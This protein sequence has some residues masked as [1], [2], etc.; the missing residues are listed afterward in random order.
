MLYPELWQFCSYGFYAQEKK[1]LPWLLFLTFPL[2]SLSFS[3]SLSLCCECQAVSIT[4][5]QDLSF[6]HY[7]K[8]QT[9]SRRAGGG[10]RQ[11]SG[12]SAISRSQGEKM[13][14][15]LLLWGSLITRQ[16][17]NHPGLFS[18]IQLGCFPTPV[19]IPKVWIYSGRSKSVA[20]VTD[21][22]EFV[23]QH[24][25]RLWSVTIGTLWEDSTSPFW[26]SIHCTLSL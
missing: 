16:L 8:K 14:P 20:P 21:K 3:L 24:I 17:I 13:K 12:C 4:V 26:V 11:A 5:W 23:I 19:E 22:T 15:N 25:L 9:E 10:D 1:T 6:W 2:P 7:T 18:F